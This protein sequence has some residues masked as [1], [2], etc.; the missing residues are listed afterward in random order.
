MSTESPLD[1]AVR[2]ALAGRP[3]FPCHT[4]TPAGCSCGRPDCGS[5]GKHPR[6]RN[7]LHDA[8]TDVGRIES[9]WS[10]WRDANVGVATGRV[11]G[12]VVIDIDPRHGGLASMRA[13]LDEHGPL[14]DGPRVR[15]GSGGWHL[16]FSSPAAPVKNSVNRVGPGIDVRSDGGYVIAPPSLH[17]VGPRYEWTKH[18]ETPRLPGWLEKL[19]TPS[20]PERR[21][22]CEPLPVSVAIDR[23]AAAALQG[24]VDRVRRAP[25]GSRNHALNRAA[26]ALGQIAGA[27][28]I[29][30]SDVEAHLRRAAIS[31]G[32]GEREADLTIR[33]GFSAGLARPRGPAQPPT[34]LTERATDVAQPQVEPEV[35][36]P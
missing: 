30:S 25:E 5:P 31:V 10:R 34:R 19:V 1:A 11:S 7:G 17:P 13:L 9:W 15:T 12:L 16:L 6:T 33:S 18:G 3:V 28:A 20:V 23:W 14:P 22:Q 36:L 29:D 35:T 2:Y 32:L 24:E 8:T 26:F 4:P 21:P 27:G